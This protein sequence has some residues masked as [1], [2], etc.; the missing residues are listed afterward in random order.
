MQSFFNGIKNSILV[1]L[2]NCIVSLRLAVDKVTIKNIN[3]EMAKYLA[4]ADKYD[5]KNNYLLIIVNK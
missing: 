2:S 5:F 4:I 3:F 1:N